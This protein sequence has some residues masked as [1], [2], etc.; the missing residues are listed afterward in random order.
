MFGTGALASV[1]GASGF[2]QVLE[3]MMECTP[4]LEEAGMPP[5]SCHGW[6]FDGGLEAMLHVLGS[7]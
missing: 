6:I 4:D 1:V 5:D 7:G 2:P 3:N